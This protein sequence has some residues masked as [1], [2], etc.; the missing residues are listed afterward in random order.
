MS[1]LEYINVKTAGHTNDDL[2]VRISVSRCGKITDGVSFSH[3]NEGCWVVDFAD[4]ER[5][6][7]ANKAFRAQP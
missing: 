2:C 3:G 4:L 7:L 5:I 1:E 6:Y